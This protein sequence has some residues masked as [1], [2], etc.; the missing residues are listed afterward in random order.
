MLS[1]AIPKGSLSESIFQLF[2]Q[3]ELPIRKSGERDYQ[4]YIDDPRIKET[5]M[6]RAQEIP[7]EVEDNEFDLGITGLDWIQERNA[8]VKE[9]SD[10]QV[11][12]K[13]QREVKIVLATH[14]DNPAEKAENIPTGSKIATEYPNLTKQFFR[15]IGKEVDI[16]PSWGATEAKVPRLA[17]YLVDITE[18]GETLKK[19]GKKIISV[20]LRSSTK[21]ITNYQAWEDPAKRQAIKEISELLASALEAEGKILLKLNAREENLPS[22]TE[23]LPALRSP[24]VSSLYNNAQK[25]EEKWFGVEAVVK[26]SE[27]N[28][29]IPKLKD[30][31]AEGIL[32]LS[33][34]KL[35]Y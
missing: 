35:M 34:S 16:K 8:K 26:K 17:S 25:E 13:A 9:V 14:E 24:T 1:I 7:A 4:L 29:I 10:L 22:I 3:A 11:A 20:L 30:L 12:K 2:E 6:L 28:L 18:T 31:G 27:L 5:F 19:N 33:I 21:L 15:K 32:E 23:Y